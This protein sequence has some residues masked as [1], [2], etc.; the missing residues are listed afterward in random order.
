M[1]DHDRADP[2]ALPDLSPRGARALTVVGAVL[3]VAALFQLAILLGPLGMV[4]GLVAHLKG[5]RYGFKVAV[6]AGITTVVGMSLAFLV[7]NPFEG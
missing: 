6:V 5:D 4:A 2:D 7:V 1:T 3:A